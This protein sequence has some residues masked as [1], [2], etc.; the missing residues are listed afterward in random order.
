[1]KVSRADLHQKVRVARHGNIILLV[2]D[3]SGSMAALQRMEA[4]K[5]AV[6]SL[7]G[8]AYKRRDQ[9]GVIS[10]RGKEAELVLPPTR[11]VEIAEE[12]LRS[13]PTGGRTPLAHALALATKT[14]SAPGKDD[15]PE[16]LLV[17]LSDGK[18]NVAL[19]GGG[20]PWQQSLSAA[21][22]LAE[23]SVPS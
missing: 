5:G 8:D 17:V 10:C 6:I 2:V 12:R 20:D 13:L 19:P 9:V 1:L 16:P 7:L 15:R 22:S 3:S 23:L 4:V 14:L 18:A 11:S 21:G